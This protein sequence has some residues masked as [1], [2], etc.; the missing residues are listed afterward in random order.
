MRKIVFYALILGILASC[1]TNEG[2]GGSCEI[3]G[4]LFTQAYNDDNSIELWTKPSIDEDVFIIYGD[5]S[6]IGDDTKTSYT[7]EFRFKYLWPGKYSIY[8][9]SE[10][11]LGKEEANIHE[12]ELKKNEKLNLGELTQ[13]KFLEFDEGTASISGQIFL[14]NYRNES[15][16]PNMMVKDTSWAQEKEVYLVYGDHEQYDSRIRTNYDGTFSFQNLI[17]GDYLL[18]VYSE[19]LKGGTQD[20]VIKRE[21]TISEENE[22]RIIEDIFTEKI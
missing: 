18:Y 16:W 14:I 17:K 10:N 12:V 11:E 4:T 8:Y 3:H 21:I 19:D 20:I 6:V 1:N 22:D 7:G 2:V 15:I 9:F 5:E 13:K